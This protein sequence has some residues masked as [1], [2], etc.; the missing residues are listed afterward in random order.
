ME[1][2]DACRWSL[3]FPNFHFRAEN[4]FETHS[5]SVRGSGLNYVVTVCFEKKKPKFKYKVAHKKIATNLAEP[6]GVKDMS[7]QSRLFNKLKY[8]KPLYQ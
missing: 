8:L 1:Q 3:V 4:P 6:P 7:E 5:E 2:S